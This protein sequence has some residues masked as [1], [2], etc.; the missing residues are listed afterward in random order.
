MRRVPRPAALGLEY[1]LLL[2]AV[3]ELSLNR[4]AVKTL[5]PAVEETPP[6]WHTLLDHVGLFFQY[7]VTTLAVGALLIMAKR[8]VVGEGRP[9]LG[10]HGA[11]AVLLAIF[12]TVL[13]VLS[14]VNMVAPG[15]DSS[16][17]FQALFAATLVVLAFEQLA[18]RGDVASKIG[19][20]LLTVPLMLH[21]YPE[22]VYHV[23]GDET[24]RWNGLPFE[25]SEYGK[26]TV[27]LLALTS[28]LLFAPRPFLQSATKLPP[29]AVGAFTGVVG[30]VILRQHYEVGMELASRGVGVDIGPGAPDHH[31]AL[32]V[33]ALG[34][35]TWTLVSALTAAAESR[36]RI[37]VGLGLVVLGGYAFAWPFQ[38]LLGLIGLFTISDA[39]GP[40]RREE[41]DSG[42]HRG[43]GFR[44]P[45]IAGRVWQRYVAALLAGLRE[46]DTGC[47]PAS[48][49]VRGDDDVSSTHVVVDRNGVSARL[50]VDR[51]ADS[52]VCIDL[53]CGREAPPGAKP[54]WTLYAR[55][56]RMLGI[57]PHDEPPD[58][59]G[60]VVK[61]GDE[62][63]D[64]RFRVRDA[65]RLTPQ[66]F[67]DA[68]RSRS[69]ALID[70]WLACWP[71]RCLQY[72]VYPGSGAP[73]DHPIPITELAFRGDS[74]A[75]AVDRLLTV[76]DVVTD[77]AASAGLTRDAVGESAEHA[78]ADLDLDGDE[79]DG[80]EPDGDEPGGDVPASS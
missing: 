55:P 79:P 56:D 53:L 78:I 7:F 60:P 46:A 16:T 47:K 18:T 40:A 52:I 43:R 6:L 80:D 39:A 70:G 10:L 29:L 61:T 51:L 68:R 71:E 11:P 35:I 75:P 69:T 54:R 19:V 65:V 4:L 9:R 72:R 41:R 12:A 34:A 15:P 77:L 22:F 30:A 24:V 74:A 59:E 64:S 23:L 67:D 36:R 45:P 21:F 13:A 25:F 62:P 57:R 8:M 27:V 38:Y 20:I 17:V 48:V 1:V 31:I 73:L 37:G 5:R 42:G 32:Y 58:C 44:S 26:W 50:R 33:V 3:V 28:P 49:T 66:L 63:F 14:V 76:I 2:A